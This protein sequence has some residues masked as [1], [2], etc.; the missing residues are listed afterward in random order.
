MAAKTIHRG[1]KEPKKMVFSASLA[2]PLRFNAFGG[3]KQKPPAF[4]GGR[5]V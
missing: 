4:A 1:S 5:F 2:K 3:Q